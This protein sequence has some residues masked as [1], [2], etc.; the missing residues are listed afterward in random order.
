MN[1]RQVVFKNKQLSRMQTARIEMPKANN[2][3]LIMFLS[4]YFI[5]FSWP[6]III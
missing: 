2:I 4:E 1:T 5:L 6:Y 3:I